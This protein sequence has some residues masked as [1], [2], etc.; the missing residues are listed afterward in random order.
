MAQSSIYLTKRFVGM[1]Y[2]DSLAVGTIFCFV[3]SKTA[4]YWS[5][6]AD[7]DA[8]FQHVYTDDESDITF[9]HANNKTD[10]AVRTRKIRDFRERILAARAQKEREAQLDAYNY[11]NNKNLRL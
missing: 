4:S 2:R 11:L 9:R 10:S 7:N 3:G 5:K 8:V 1:N 6:S